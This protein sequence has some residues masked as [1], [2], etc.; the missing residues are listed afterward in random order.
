MKQSRTGIFAR[1]TPRFKARSYHGLSAHS[2]GAN[3]KSS[4]L[5]SEAQKSAA[6]V[7]RGD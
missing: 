3:A 1:E 2:H 4:V 5:K 6:P 7:R